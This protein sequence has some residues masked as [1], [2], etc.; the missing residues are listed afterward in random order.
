[1]EWLFKGI[2]K[3]AYAISN[4]VVRVMY[5]PKIT[6]EDKKLTKEA[7]KAGC[8][9]YCN[10]TSLNDGLYLPR[11]VGNSRVHTFTGKDWF[12]KKSLHWLFRNLPFIPVDRKEMDTAWLDLG[13]QKLKEHYPIFIFPEGKLSKTR[14]PHEFKPGFLML[15][16]RAECPV[17]PVCVDGTYR[18][19]RS[20]HIIVGKPQNLNL[21]EEGRPSIVLKKYCGIC[22]DTILQLK[23]VYGEPKN[24][25]TADAISED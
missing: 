3:L 4:V 22:R 1:M 13:V 2:A 9:I 15:A 14:I 12:E 10:H 5:F 16:K 23:E 11:V 18:L 17:I 20:I 19:F 24:R 21:Q 7:L 25:V 8:V 6:W